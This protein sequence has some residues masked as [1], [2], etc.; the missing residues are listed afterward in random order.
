MIFMAAVQLEDPH[1]FPDYN[2]RSDSDAEDHG[3]Q[4]EQQETDASTTSH[5]HFG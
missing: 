4:R 2:Y 1:L 3:K 5:A